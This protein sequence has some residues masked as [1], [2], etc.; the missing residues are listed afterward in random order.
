MTEPLRVVLEH[1]ERGD[2]CLRCKQ[3]PV[4]KQG[5]GKRGTEQINV[6]S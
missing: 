1:G 5:A 6:P 3:L 4:L 2:N